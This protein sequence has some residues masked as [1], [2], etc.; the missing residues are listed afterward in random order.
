MSTPLLLDNYFVEE[1]HVE[2][3]RD[4]RRGE[5][6]D[7]VLRVGVEEARERRGKD[8]TQPVS[9]R[10]SIKTN[11]KA[12]EFKHAQY[13]VSLVLHGRFRIVPGA[14]KELVEGLI[15]L[16]APAILYG[17]ARGHVAQATA[18]CPWGRTLLPAVNFIDLEQEKRTPKKKTRKKAKRRTKKTSR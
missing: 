3:N 5:K 7:N 18:V 17:L 15:A 6:A 9:V 4:Y 12:N 11:E 1:F 8:G 2:T 14:S 10:L 13:R 16:N